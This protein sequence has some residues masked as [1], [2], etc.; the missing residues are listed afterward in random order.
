MPKDKTSLIH[1]FR[2]S[3]T[4]AVFDIR[5]R[6]RRSVI[7]P[8]W[9]TISMGITAACIGLVFGG[10]F[11]TPM[12]K[13]L[14]SI[15]AGLIIWTLVAGLLT[16]GCT[17]LIESEGIIKQLNIPF[18][19]H[20]LRVAF[21]QLFIFGH[22]FL[23]LPIVL[24]FFGHNLSLISLLSIFG[25]ALAI[26]FLS[27][28]AMFFA[29][30]SARYR[31]LPQVL[32]SVLQI[33]FYLTPIIWLP[34]MMPNRTGIEIL[35]LNPFYHLVELIRAPLLGNFPTATSIIIISILS[36]IS[37]SITIAFFINYKRRLAY[38]L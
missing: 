18:Y 10:I 3:L 17:S 4:L 2:L 25:L 15:T 28:V 31:D 29:I 22:N 13:I 14:P 16:E 9:L 27:S 38:W 37:W 34:S 1:F 26:F 12:E 6:Y 24:L 5:G 7:G 21:R 19:V 35:N 30:F 32:S 33:A 8:F 20:I 23:I 11:N 36:I